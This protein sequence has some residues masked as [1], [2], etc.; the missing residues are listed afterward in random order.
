[1]KLFVRSNWE[2]NL[3]VCRKCGKRLGGGFGD[4]GKTPLVKLLR[5]AIGGKGRNARIGVVEVKCLGICPGNGV[6]VV[7]S[8]EPGRWRIVRAGTPTQEVIDMLKLGGES[9]LATGERSQA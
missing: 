5:K 6:T 1:M 9:S 7:D 4:K 2:A 8:R 3:L